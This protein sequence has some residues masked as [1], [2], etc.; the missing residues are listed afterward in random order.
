LFH[1]GV[2]GEL[3]RRQQMA[4]TMNLISPPLQVPQ[5][6]H[7]PLLADAVSFP[8]GAGQ[9][10]ARP[11]ASPPLACVARSDTRNG[12]TGEGWL[13]LLSTHA[14]CSTS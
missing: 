8:P 4:Q 5:R 14:A 12:F 7:E 3:T 1:A 13:E 10:P 2:L 9:P 11:A 6:D